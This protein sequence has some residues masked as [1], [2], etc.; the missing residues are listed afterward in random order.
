MHRTRLSHLSID[1]VP[2]LFEACVPAYV[3]NPGGDGV[4]CSE[5]RNVVEV[6]A[7]GLGRSVPVGVE[8]VVSAYKRGQPLEAE[9]AGSRASGF[10]F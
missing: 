2:Q 9:P 1:V 6:P 4:G 7:A 8:V 5:G 3:P 10:T